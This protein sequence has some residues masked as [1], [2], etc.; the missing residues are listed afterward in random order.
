MTAE[1]KERGKKKSKGKI[2]IVAGGTGGHIFPALAFGCWILA[3]NKAKRVSYL[4]GD[5]PLECDI[6]ASQGIEHDCLPLSGSPLG[7]FSILRNVGRWMELLRSFFW[8]GHFLRRERPDACFLF[9]GYVSLLPLLWC[10][11]LKIPVLAHE[12]NACAGKVTKLASRLGVPVATGWS[13]CRGLK[14]SF[15]PVGVPVRPVQKISQQTAA[16]ALGIEIGTKI[17]DEELRVGVVGGSLGSASLSALIGKISEKRSDIG[18]NPLFIVLGSASAAAQKTWVRFIERRWDMT[19]FYSLCDAVICRAGASTL[20]ELA[21]YQI[22]TLTIPW[23]EAADGHQEANARCFVASTGNLVW[24]E[25]K[26]N[27]EENEE[28]NEEKEKNKKNEGL[29]KTFSELLR[30]ARKARDDANNGNAQERNFTPEAS[31]ALWRF[32][33]KR[34]CLL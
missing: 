9:G 17:K 2:L 28:E 3:Q 7:S 19:P 26:E 23:K 27:A 24:F 1:G 11:L 32:A 30:R 4:S 18:E 13:Q 25:S 16:S 8:M 10:R 12:Q 14:G 22:P 31:L 21:A 6:Y 29:E 20:A 34:L 33:E 5:R 15:T